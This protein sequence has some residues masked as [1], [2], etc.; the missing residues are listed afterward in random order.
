MKLENAIYNAPEMSNEKLLEHID[1]NGN[2]LTKNLKDRLWKL[3]PNIYEFNKQV[4]SEFNKIQNKTSY[5]SKSQ[6]DIIS[7]LVSFSLITMTKD[8]GTSNN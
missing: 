7:G 3:N 8:D 4:V 1:K 2:M 6:R 5:L